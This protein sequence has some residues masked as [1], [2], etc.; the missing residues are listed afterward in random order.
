MHD[1][2]RFTPSALREDS[3]VDIELRSLISTHCENGVF[4]FVCSEAI[5]NIPVCCR[6][7][8]PFSWSISPVRKAALNSSF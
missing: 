2:T 7:F 1:V 4:S 5:S 8:T 6:N 3:N